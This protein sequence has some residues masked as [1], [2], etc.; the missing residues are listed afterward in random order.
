MG[1]PVQ[2]HEEEA[3]ESL[4]RPQGVG[5]GSELTFCLQEPIAGE[6]PA[7]QVAL[8][9]ALH[10]PGGRQSLPRNKAARLRFRM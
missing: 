2:S 10:H 9:L 4:Q 8:F 3:L 6:F 7:R 5:L 1:G